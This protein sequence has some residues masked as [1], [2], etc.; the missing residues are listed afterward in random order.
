M[1]AKG[2]CPQCGT[3]K[4]EIQ[5]TSNIFHLIMSIVTSGLWLPIWL[6]SSFFQ[7]AKCSFCGGNATKDFFQ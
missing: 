4:V 7:I 1:I 6:I 2:K 3:V 5:K